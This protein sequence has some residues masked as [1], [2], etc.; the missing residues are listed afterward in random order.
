MMS[1]RAQMSTNMGHFY[2]NLYDFGAH[3][4]TLHSERV[5]WFHSLLYESLAKFKQ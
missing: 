2:G 4:S 5:L 1:A 3:C